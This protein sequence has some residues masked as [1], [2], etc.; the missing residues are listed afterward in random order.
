M[1]ELANVNDNRYHLHLVFYILKNMISLDTAKKNQ[2]VIID[3]ILSDNNQRDKLLNL[4]IMLG[5]KARVMQN[6]GGSVIVAI[7]EN[8]VSLGKQISKLISI[9]N[10]R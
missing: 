6:V 1:Q 4:G 7:D 9:K 2:I 5:I 3:D 10:F 8:R